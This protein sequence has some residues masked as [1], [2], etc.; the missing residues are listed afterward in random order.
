MPTIKDVAKSAGVAPITASRVINHSG[1]VSD[2]TRR[3]VEQAIDAL[4]YIP[5]RVARSLRS[6]QTNLV[7]LV[8]TDITNPF[9]TTVARG[10]EDAASE[11]GFSVILC[12]TDE[13]KIKQ[14][15]YVRNLLQRQVDGFLIVPSEDAPVVL[16][17]IQKQSV[18]VVVLDREVKEDVD[19]VRSDSFNGAVQLTRLLLDL[20]HHHIAML[21]GPLGVS[22]AVD[23]VQGYLNV[24]GENGMPVR[25]EFIIYGSFTQ[26]GGYDMCRTILSV[27][28]RP[29]A[30]FAGN[31]F[32]AVGVLRALREVGLRVPEDMALVAFDDLPP[33]YV[34]D[35]F[36]T[37]AAQSAYEMGQIA[38]QILL[39]RM[40]GKG[41]LPTQ[42]ILLP[43]QLI[44]RQSSG[45]KIS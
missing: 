14:D 29:T 5:N 20:G 26:Q 41:T 15:A 28:P 7:A 16:S 43:T 37:V 27:H 17:L 1:Y 23:R 10:V 19:T 9:W 44:I 32:I 42:E 38:T 24:L 39:K 2:S 11:G 31:N 34:I 8:L 45:Q 30:I 18:P 33:T 35:P 4:G 3:R 36:L 21:S 12:N 6:K 13:S 40:E 22:T 25:S